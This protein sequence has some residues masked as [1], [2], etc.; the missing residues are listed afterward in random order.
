M[1]TKKEDH[2]EEEIISR[3]VAYS[4]VADVYADLTVVTT[5]HSVK[6]GNEKRNNIH[7]FVLISRASVVHTSIYQRRMIFL[8]HCEIMGRLLPHMLAITIVGSGLGRWPV[9]EI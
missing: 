4:L 8:L 1:T 9:R 7:F 6:S 2:V 5:S 3:M